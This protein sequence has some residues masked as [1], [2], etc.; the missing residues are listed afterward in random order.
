MQKKVK[1][2]DLLD[3]TTRLIA[4]LR[5]VYSYQVQML[6]NILMFDEK[7]PIG[8]P[9]AIGSKILIQPIYNPRRQVNRIHFTTHIP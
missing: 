5:I 2:K 7:K 8:K 4:T 3:L 9:E 1:R 6:H